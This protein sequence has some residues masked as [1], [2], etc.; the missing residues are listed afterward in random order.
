[1][2]VIVHRKLHKL[3]IIIQIISKKLSHLTRIVISIEQN[4]LIITQVNYARIVLSIINKMLSQKEILN[5]T[6]IA[7]SSK[8]K[9]TKIV[10]YQNKCLMIFLKAIKQINI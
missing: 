6:I 1:M 2:L 4:N 8:T 7:F 3:L 9:Q 10:N 5:Q